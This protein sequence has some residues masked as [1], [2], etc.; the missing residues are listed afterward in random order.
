MLS[1]LL[2]VNQLKDQVCHLDKE[3]KKLRPELENTQNRGL[4]KTLIFKNIPFQ[5]QCHNEL[6]DESKEI[7]TKEIIKVL[8]EFLVS[9]V[10]K[11]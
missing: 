9:D 2:E 10:I 1:N 5:Q 8:L 11:K 4:R 7:L 3:M 6:W